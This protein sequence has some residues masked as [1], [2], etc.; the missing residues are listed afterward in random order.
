MYG[1]ARVAEAFLLL[2][3]ARLVSA[4]LPMDVTSK[5][6]GSSGAESP[7]M[8][9][10]DQVEA[11]RRVGASIQAALYLTPF[12]AEC[13]PQAIAGKLMLA[14]RGI[15]ATVYLGVRKMYDG[16]LDSHAWLRV[17]EEVVTGRHLPGTYATVC[18]FA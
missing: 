4:R 16:A 18:T 5:V 10:A 13:L 1:G 17:G 3:A 14:R 7:K 2:G 6:L 9:S 12:E 8:L 15:P 11:A